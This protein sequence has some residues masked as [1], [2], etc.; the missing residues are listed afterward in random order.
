MVEE[1]VPTLF[2]GGSL[3]GLFVLKH[4][5]D[6]DIAVEHGAAGGIDVFGVKAAYGRI[7]QDG[8]HTVGGGNNHEAISR[9][10]ERIEG[11]D[12]KCGV[13]HLL[14]KFQFVGG[15]GSFG[16]GGY[17]KIVSTHLFC[18]LE[19]DVVGFCGAKHK[20]NDNNTK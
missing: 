20:G 19:V 11:R 5:D 9:D 6:F 7:G 1:F 17:A 18:S 14:N 15:D 13:V 8:L 10:I 16:P 3:G 4:A 2:V 12:A